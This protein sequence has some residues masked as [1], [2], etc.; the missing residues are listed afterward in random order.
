MKATET[1][2]CDVIKTSPRVIRPIDQR[3]SSWTGWDGRPLWGGILRAGASPDRRGR[4]LG[5]VVS[6][7]GKPPSPD[8]PPDAVGL[9]RQSLETQ[10]GIG[11]MP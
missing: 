7:P 8:D 9:V 1:D 4:V 10:F 2:L 3:A 6:I 5:S 11:A